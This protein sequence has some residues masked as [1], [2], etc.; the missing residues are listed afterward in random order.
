MAAVSVSLLV[1]RFRKNGPQVLL[2]HPGGPVWQNK[3]DGA[4][5]L[6]KRDVDA[7]VAGLPAAQAE[8]ERQLGLHPLGQPAELK[9]VK[10][11]SGKLLHGWAVQHDCE[12]ANIRS[13]VEQMEW[14]P[15][16]G[17]QIEFAEVD[18]AVFFDLAVAKRKINAGQVGLLQEL[19]AL[20]GKA[21]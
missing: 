19:E 17:K 12:P 21:K 10:Q 14:P 13:A 8:F 18:R 1:Y 5:M 3:D 6:T 9:P 2:A 11:K 15:G 4:W 16:T 7:G 20:L